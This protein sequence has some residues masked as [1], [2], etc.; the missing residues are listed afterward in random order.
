MLDGTMGSSAARRGVAVM[1]VAVAL[2]VA[3]PAMPAATQ[4]TVATGTP[5]TG[6]AAICAAVTAGTLATPGTADDHDHGDESVPTDPGAVVLAPFDLVYI[7]AMAARDAGTAT[8]GRLIADRATDARVRD[9]GQTLAAG[10]E[11]NVAALGAWREAW[12]PAAPTP[13]DL[14]LVQLVDEAEAGAGAAADGGMGGGDPAVPEDDLLTLCTATDGFDSVALE[15][16]TARIVTDV[17]LAAIAFGRAER[18]ELLGFARSRGESGEEE[19]ARIAVLATG[20]VVGTPP[21]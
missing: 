5:V 9:L 4:E 10:G 12:Y 15:I 6:A 21:V 16:V 3:R 18:V 8:I 19:L 2:A 14:Q 17:A 7:D 20:I 13:D 11:A 1:V